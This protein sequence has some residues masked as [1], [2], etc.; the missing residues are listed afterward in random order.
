MGL[1]VYKSYS[2]EYIKKRFAPY[3]NL[4][5]Y[6]KINKDLECSSD[7]KKEINIDYFD[8]KH[9]FDLMSP[10]LVKVVFNHPL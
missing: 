1:W 2:W 8:T 7:I 10:I 6:D 5:I 9:K 3:N 4:R